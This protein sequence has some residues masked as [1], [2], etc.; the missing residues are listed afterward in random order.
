MEIAF[1][2]LIAFTIIFV[3]RLHEHQS[4]RLVIAK[5]G[6]TLI[7]GI[8]QITEADDVT[9][10]LHRIQNS[11]RTTVGL[12]QSVHLQVLVHPKRVQRLGVKTRQEHTHYYQDIDLLVLHAERHILVVV[13]E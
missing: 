12:Q 8:F 4:A 10:V 13:L 11:V 6:Q 7:S 3:E 2:V 9:A 5:D 1:F